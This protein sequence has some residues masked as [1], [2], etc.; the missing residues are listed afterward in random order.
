[1]SVTITNIK[2][3]KL[4]LFNDAINNLISN[5]YRKEAI[6]KEL[7]NLENYQIWKYKKLPSGKKAISLKQVFKVKYQPNGSVAKF[8]ARLVTQKLYQV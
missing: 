4:G 2:I 7:Q 6:K 8:K 5:W 3:Y 1:M